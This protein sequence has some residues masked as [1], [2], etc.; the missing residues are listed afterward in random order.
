MPTPQRSLIGHPGAIFLAPNSLH[1]FKSIFSHPPG[2]AERISFLGR[3]N[4]CRAGF[5]VP[6]KL[7]WFSWYPVLGSWP[8]M[9]D[10]PGRCHRHTSREQSTLD[11]PHRSLVLP[12]ASLHPRDR[13][14]RARPGTPH[15]YKPANRG[16]GP[17]RTR[18]IDLTM[19]AK[20]LNIV[21]HTCMRQAATSLSA[22]VFRWRLGCPTGMTRRVRPDP[23]RR[24][25]TSPESITDRSLG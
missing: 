11:H 8:S 9:E 23:N 15:P 18:L 25:Q 2:T 17:L 10:P 24:S 13:S 16:T 12:T 14:L 22:T 1:I 3:I 19:A 21:V 4:L 20:A 7:R 5:H 6:F